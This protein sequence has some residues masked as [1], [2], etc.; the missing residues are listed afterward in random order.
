[1][2]HT[3]TGL[4]RLSARASEIRPAPT[5]AIASR[6]RQMRLEGIDVISFS[7]GEPDFDTPEPIAAAGIEAI[8]SGFTHYTDAT[9][10]QELRAAVARKFVEENGVPST[11]ETVLVSSGGKH[12]IFNVLAAIVDPGDNVIIQSPYWVSYPS[13]VSILGGTPRIVETTFEEGY[14]MTPAGLLAAIDERTRCIILNSPSNPT[15]V[16]Y[17]PDE[18][19]AFAEIARDR[20]CYLLSDEL[21]EK[22]VYGTVPHFS[23]GS[24]EGMADQVITV[25]GVSKAWAMTGWRIGYATGPADVIRAAGA[26]QSQTTSNPT[27][28][29]Q[30]AALAAVTN[31]ADEAER[32]RCAFERR[33]ELI[34]SELVDVPGFRIVS[35]DGA[36]Y[37][38]ADISPLLGDRFTGS[39]DFSE[40]LLVDHAVAVVPG[41]AFGNDAG[42]RISYACSD[43]DIRRGMERIREGVRQLIG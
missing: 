2:D 23:V 29:S 31:G 33:R 12:A 9:G 20:G 7:T 8:R 36:F 42:I 15:G 26:I 14:R 25:N 1:M 21:Y 32:L 35:P 27:S 19:R 40:Y 17:S 10:I 39:I 22:I 6:A 28:I 38:F 34:L 13:L 37:V 18:L 11:A 5:L 24:I 30:V 43:E 41:I 16:M 3:K 4:R